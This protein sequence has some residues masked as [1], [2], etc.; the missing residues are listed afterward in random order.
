MIIQ[1]KEVWFANFPFVEDENQSKDRP[2]IV[3]EVDDETFCQ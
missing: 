1:P 2:V 3:L